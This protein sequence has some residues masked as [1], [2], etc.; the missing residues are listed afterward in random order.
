MAYQNV[1]G[2]HN[3]SSTCART[4]Q[5]GLASAAL[6][7]ARTTHP[8]LASASAFDR[9]NR[10]CRKIAKLTAFPVS[11]LY[12]T[13]YTH[14]PAQA[15]CWCVLV[16]LSICNVPHTMSLRLATGGTTNKH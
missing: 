5:R 6:T 7:G 8:G 1:S 2:C 13:S 11:H 3:N 14:I 9:S 10:Y 4:A 12:I 15:I 16:S